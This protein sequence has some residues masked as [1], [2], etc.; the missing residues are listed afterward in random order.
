MDG[1]K[2]VLQTKMLLP[3]KDIYQIKAKLLDLKDL[4]P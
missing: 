3:F 1:N 4:K 2:T